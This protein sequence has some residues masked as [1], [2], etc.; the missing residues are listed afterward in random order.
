MFRFL[1]LV[2]LAAVFA[3]GCSSS[4]E[5]RMERDIS[6]WRAEA[7]AKIDQGKCKAEGGSIKGIG[8]YGLPA[9]V[10]PFPDAGKVCSD[11]S[12][13][14]GMCKAKDDAKIG[15]HPTTGNCQNDPADIFGCINEIKGG[16]VV[17]GWCI[18]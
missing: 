7:L 15:A 18:D 2:S 14:H 8:M 10:I 13:C 6:R 9:C 16:E 1:L 11:R 4:G 12:E 5:S 3:N 17:A